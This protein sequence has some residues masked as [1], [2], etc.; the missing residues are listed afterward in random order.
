MAWIVTAA[1]IGAVVC[2]SCSAGVG[3]ALEYPPVFIGAF[4]L[5]AIMQYT[6][7]RRARALLIIL[8]AFSATSC[9]PAIAQAPAVAPS[10]SLPFQNPALPFDQRVD[11]LVGRMTLTEKISQMQTDAA[12]I[13]R[14]GIPKYYWWS[15]CLHG[16]AFGQATVFP[17]PMGLA[18]SWDLALES[19]VA[20]AISDEDRAEF[21][22]TYFSGNS[23]P[24]H[25]A[26][27]FAPN[28][29]IFRDPRWGRG[30]ETYGEDPYLTSRFGVVF[31]EGLQGSDPKYFKVIATPKH[32]AVHSG[33]EPQRHVFDS[34]I[35]QYDLYDTYLPAFE[36]TVRE[37]HA[38]S[39]MG[40]YSSLFGVPCNA[41]PLLLQT[42]LRDKWG[43]DGYVVSD[44]GAIEDIY[45]NHKYAKS[46]PEACADAVKAGCDLCCSGAYNALNDAV[47]QGLITEKEIDVS[48]K[49]LFTARMKLGMFDPP[50]SVPFDSIPMTV[51]DSPDHIS[52]ALQAARESLV[53]L[54]NKGDFLPLPSHVRSIAVIGPNADDREVLH[55]NYNGMA[56]NPITVLQGIK[57]RAGSGVTVDYDMGS[58]ILDYGTFMES[59]PSSVLSA[60]G[61]PGLHGVYFNTMDLSGDPAG[62]RQDAN[63]DYVWS[64][65]SPIAGLGQTAYSVR[66]TGELTP[67]V[68]GQYSIGVAGD[69][70]YRLFIDDKKVIDNWRDEPAT[71][72]SATVALQAGKAVK[73]VLEYYQDTGGAEVHLR[74]QVPGAKPFA[75]AL[76][77]ARKD[78]VVVFVGGINSSYEGEEGTH[79]NGDRSDIALPAVQEDLLHQIA[80][81]GKPIVLVMMN[82]S[83]LAVNWEKGAAS[84]PAIIEA[85]YPG[86]QGGVA[87]AEALFGDYNPAGRLPV[88]FYTGNDQLPA[89]TDYA[90]KNRTY[91]YFDGTPLY[92]FGYG[93]SY[94]KFAYSNLHVPAHLRAGQPALV[95]VTVKNAGRRSGDEVVEVYLR[96]APDAAKRQISP[97][98]PM[99]RLELAGFQ[100][101]TLDA[102]QKQTITFTLKPDQLTL[103]KSD[104]ER[105]LQPGQWQVY[106]GGRQPSI[107][108]PAAD[109]VEV[110]SSRF[111]ID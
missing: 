56:A 36:A 98:Q 8:A 74:W 106:V 39:V 38:Q 46:M 87:V 10:S 73:I 30:Q 99:P 14:L 4:L 105:S 111:A 20:T 33:P 21:N 24:F 22:A 81:L 75:R 47:S 65:Q 11:D 67:P 42:N 48:V 35:S 76:S 1:L 61:K 64:G 32:F 27:F 19:K 80:A 95:T 52:L 59:V 66:W 89:F 60:G 101:V 90:M 2:G 13:P 44:C 55:G 84:V 54:K 17:E 77:L 108:N 25:G 102:G 43:F 57:S 51:V 69:D 71:T 31:V 34:E 23:Q 62:D 83:A 26:T 82:G 104:G 93:L 100:R 15:E 68:D 72:K 70:G 85:W 40:A 28:I 109:A 49:R 78:S 53:L 94:T 29:N 79:G 50:T 86:E 12:A 88:T 16:F 5:A 58:E 7:R 63:V 92:E 18:S 41:S 103:V 37:A 97:D 9:C 3:S 91:R 107:K 6:F 96:P 45:Y 110:Q